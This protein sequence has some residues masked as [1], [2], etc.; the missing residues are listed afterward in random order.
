MLYVTAIG[1]SAPRK[2]VAGI[3]ASHPC[4]QNPS[5]LPTR[6]PFKLKLFLLSQTKFTNLLV[7]FHSNPLHTLNILPFARLSCSVSAL[8]AWDSWRWAAQFI[9]YQLFFLCLVAQAHDY[10]SPS[11]RYPCEDVNMYYANVAQF[12]GELLKRKLNSI[13][14]A[15]HSLSYKEVWDAIKILDAAD[16]DNPEA[17]SAIVEIYS[18]RIVP[19][20][21]AGKPEGWNREHLWPR[22]YGLRR[23]P[24]LTDL[25]NIHPADTNVNSSRGNKYFGEC[26]VKS[27]EC[28]K[29]AS[30]E[31]ASDTESDKE[32]WAPP[33]HVR[34]DIARAV[35]YMAV[36]YGF[37]LSDSP[38][39]GNNEMG[40]LS[41]LLKWNKGDPPSREEKLRNDRI[42]KFYQHNRNPFIDHPEYAQLIWKQISPI[43]ESSKFLKGKQ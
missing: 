36:S 39:K 9:S 28:L 13:V 43:R 38:N 31:A 26:Q 15:H 12:K 5:S 27:P 8:F 25:H 1:S 19:K 20:S 6:F 11:V 40:L 21:L 16:V 35:M 34:G 4:N 32:K 29:P 33:K 17:S 41:T 30:K 37:Q 18:Q 23:G 42:C 10:P 14:A 2:L 22:S 3:E 24:S 7:E